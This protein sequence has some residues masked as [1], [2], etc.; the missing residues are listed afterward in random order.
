MIKFLQDKSVLYADD[1]EIVLESTIYTLSTFFDTI[2]SA[3]NGEE[4]YQIYEEK[5]PNVIILDVKMPKMSGL[6]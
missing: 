1:D 6:N 5:K 4:A 3:R 2:Y